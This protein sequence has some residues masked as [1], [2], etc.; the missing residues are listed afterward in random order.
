MARKESFEAAYQDIADY[1]YNTNTKAFTTFDLTNIFEKNRDIWKIASYRTAKHFFK[2]LDNSRILRLKTLKHQSTG[3]IKTILSKEDANYYDIALTIKK[4]GYLSNYTA[5]S[6]HQLTLQI[7]KSIYISSMKSD[8]GKRNSNEVN[9]EQHSIDQ[10]FAKPQ[11]ITSEVYKSEIDNYRLFFI[12]KGY[13]E[14]E[15]GLESNQGITYTDLERTLIDIALRPAYSG[16]VFEVLEAYVNAR[17]VIDTNKLY[18]YLNQLNYIYPYHQLIGFYLEK[19]NYEEKRYLM[20]YE[21][22][23]SL[24]F[25][26]TY[27][28]SNKQY[29]EKWKIYFP[30]GF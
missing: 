12:Q 20:F 13:S 17:E 26:L 24:K 23:S 3:S 19:A 15:I 21:N 22:I 11:R 16:G 18:N 25:Y 6:I 10:A 29:D 7:P 14:K 9:L 28:I 5:M 30:K 1:F 27:N 4:D 8:D 2:Y